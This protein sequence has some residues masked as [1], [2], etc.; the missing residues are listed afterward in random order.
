MSPEATFMH[1]LEFSIYG[2]FFG[3]LGDKKKYK[4]FQAN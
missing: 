2:A 3:A 1:L 4:K